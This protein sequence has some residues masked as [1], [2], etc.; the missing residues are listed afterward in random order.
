MMFRAISKVLLVFTL[1]AALPALEGSAAAA[2]HHHRAQG[3]KHHKKHHRAEHRARSQGHDRERGRET[4]P[5]G[6]L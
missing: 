1:A 6:E 3:R 5:T 4:P 2:T